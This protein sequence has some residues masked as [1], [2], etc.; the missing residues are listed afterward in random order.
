MPERLQAAPEVAGEQEVVVV[1]RVL[2]QRH[3]HQQVERLDRR[4]MVP[5]P[6]EDVV[7][8]EC[9]AAAARLEEGL[10]G[11]LDA[12][13]GDGLAGAVIG[14]IGRP[15]GVGAGRIQRR[16]LEQAERRGHRVVDVLVG[17]R[18]VLEDRQEAVLAVQ[19]PDQVGDG[20]QAG[21]RM[22]RAAMVA[23]REIGGADHG[24]RRGGQHC[25]GG[26]AGPQL[27]QR[28][29]Q[30]FAGGRLL[31][32]LDQRFNRFWVLDTSVH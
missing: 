22:Q 20:V 31:D 27:F 8:L 4:D 18:D 16:E 23:G 2:R 14:E 6:Q 7:G 30:D 17:Q 29:V 32:E 1:E 3:A 26:D 11:G 10:L 28:A 19:P 25:V 5:E 12:F 9:L 13:R 21:E 24:E 15:A